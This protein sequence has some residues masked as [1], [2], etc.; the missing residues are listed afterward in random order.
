M[1]LDSPGWRVVYADEES[2]IDGEL[3]FRLGR[4]A[5]APA[6]DPTADGRPLPADTNAADAELARR[7]DRG[8][9]PRPRRVATVRSRPPR[10]SARRRVSTSTSGGTARHRDIT[11]LFRYDGRV[12][13]FRAGVA[14]L[15]AFKVL[16]GA[17]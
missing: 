13:E 1:L 2:Q 16:L 4:H 8:V 9:V 12:L 5:P 6:I 11:A 17:R 15:A 7:R 14:D 10:S 3:Q